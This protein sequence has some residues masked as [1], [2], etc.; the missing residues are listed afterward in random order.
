M[1]V[2]I[3]DNSIKPSRFREIHDF[4]TNNPPII[5][6][7]ETNG[8]RI[9]DSKL[10]F[11]TLLTKIIGITIVLELITDPIPTPVTPS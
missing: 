5:N 10:T 4:M 7:A 8:E 2:P 11:I 1:V 3:T 9:F 6:S